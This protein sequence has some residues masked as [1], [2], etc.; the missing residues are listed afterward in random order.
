MPLKEIT[1]RLDEIFG[2]TEAT[3]QKVVVVYAGRFQPFHK[4]HYE[5]FTNVLKEFPH[6][7]VFI[8]TSDKVD[9]PKSPFNFKEKKQIISKM[10][11]V[12]T[13]QI[14]QIK[15]PY[16]PKEIL[17]KY[18]EDTVYITVVGKKDA[19]RL[20]KGKYFDFY[21]KGDEEME[22]YPEKGYIFIA[23]ENN[24][25]Y[26]GAPLSGTVVRDTFSNADEAEKEEL[27][28]TLYGKL[29]KKIFKLITSKIK[30]DEQFEET[31]NEGWGRKI[32]AKLGLN[33]L[34]QILTKELSDLS[35]NGFY[36]Y[37]P[38]DMALQHGIELDLRHHNYEDM[39]LI[40]RPNKDG[41]V[42]Q[43]Y[44]S[45]AISG[46]LVDVP[47]KFPV[48]A[49]TVLDIMKKIEKASVKESVEKGELASLVEAVNNKGFSKDQQKTIAT[50]LKKLGYK[51]IETFN[52]SVL[53]DYE[54]FG[55]TKSLNIERGKRLA[56]SDKRK[57]GAD[58]LTFVI[59]GENEDYPVENRWGQKVDDLDA[60]IKEMLELI[61]GS[62]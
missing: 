47:K 52:D 40:V 54:D 27:F 62:M 31:I 28:K 44:V 60:Q 41:D 57:N 10:F 35:K 7:D 5:T 39:Q 3:T 61:K 9:L 45:D 38:S 30:L 55:E 36:H 14:K 23:P 21:A 53:A 12:K 42:G 51:S 18:P 11:S 34:G 32:L 37:D 43:M 25:L 13:N 26:K 20:G 48:K 22:G 2:L 6:A 4:G 58:N 24:T 17:E 16:A 15:N 59:R 49:K 46:K 1:D 29:D 8:G 56:Y 33:P 19:E 50:Y